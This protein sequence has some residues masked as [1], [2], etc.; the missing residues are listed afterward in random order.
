MEPHEWSAVARAGRRRVERLPGGWRSR[1]PSRFGLEPQAPTIGAEISGVD[2][3]S[4]LDDDTFAELWRAL[5]EWKVL[6]FRDQHL[7]PAEHVAVA[8]RFGEVF[9]DQVTQPRKPDPLDNYVEFSHSGD[10]AG[11]DNVWHTDGSFRTDPPVALTLRAITVPAVGGDTSFADMA[12]AYDNLPDD[13]RALADTLDAEHSWACGEYARAGV[14]G[15]RHDEIATLL[16]PVRHPVARPHPLTGRRTLYVNHAF[17][18]RLV[19]GADADGNAG[20]LPAGP[21]AT[22]LLHEL[23]TQA[24]VPEYGFRLRWRPDTFVILDNQAIQHYANNDYLP[25]RRVMGRATIG[26]WRS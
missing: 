11:L 21:D 5:V 3:W 7:T 13:V 19:A 9:D 23:C 15:E 1:T 14:Y 24:A 8:A 10:D 22:A 17:T 4:P 20:D 18:S 6:V 2:L 16:P 26:R 25:D 12:V